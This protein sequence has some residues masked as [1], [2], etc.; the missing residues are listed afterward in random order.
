MNYRIS[1]KVLTL[2]KIS[3]MA[4][5]YDD[6]GEGKDPRK[7]ETEARNFFYLVIVVIISCIG[8]YVISH[9]INA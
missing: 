8:Y 1:A 9:F 2:F 6:F 4:H 3:K 7:L 5:S